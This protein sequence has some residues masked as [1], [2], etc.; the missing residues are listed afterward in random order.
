[1]CDWPEPCFHTSA[2]PVCRSATIIEVPQSTRRER[3]VGKGRVLL[4]HKKEREAGVA[5]TP[6]DTLSLGQKLRRLDPHAVGL[7]RLH[8]GVSPHHLLKGAHVGDLQDAATRFEPSGSRKSRAVTPAGSRISSRRG[9][10][11]HSSTSSTSWNTS[12][13]GMVRLLSRVRERLERYLAGYL[14]E[15]D[16]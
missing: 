7:R 3:V 2:G 13:V 6:T 10:L 9:D 12:T 8:L 15:L 5:I 11:S 14:V 16:R 4:L 1:M